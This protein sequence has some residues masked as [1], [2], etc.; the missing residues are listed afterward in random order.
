MADDGGKVAMP[1]RLYAKHTEACIGTM[2]RD[3]LHDAG[4]HFAVGLI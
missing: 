4:E 1:T 3:S 2:E